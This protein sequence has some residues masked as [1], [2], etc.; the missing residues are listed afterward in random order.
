TGTVYSVSLI[1]RG[2]QIFDADHDGL[3]DSWEMAHFGSLSF[4][5]QADPDGD[6]FN[7][8]RE[9]VMGTNPLAPDL[10]FKLDLTPWQVWGNQRMRLS[11]PTTPAT[12]YEVWGGSNVSS[13]TWIT[14]LPG[15]F[16]ETEWFTPSAPSRQFFRVRA[17]PNP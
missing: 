13:L 8:A 17:V 7:N 3:D 1:I 4:G 9:Q 6:G 14:N 5:P 15:R 16:P 2:T 11:W 12:T 10:P